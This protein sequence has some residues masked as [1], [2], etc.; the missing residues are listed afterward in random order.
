MLHLLKVDVAVHTNPYQITK[1]SRI[2]ILIH[3]LYTYIVS[4]H[5]PLI[6][7]T[8]PSKSALFLPSINSSSSEIIFV[9]PSVFLSRLVHAIGQCRCC[10]HSRFRSY[11]CA[12]SVD[13]LFFKIEGNLVE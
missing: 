4:K 11:R 2:A 7:S 9:R 5:L 3:G 6:A 13:D 1:N 12:I 10:H 8:L